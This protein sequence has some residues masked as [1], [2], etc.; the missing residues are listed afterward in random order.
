MNNWISVKA[1]MPEEDGRYL[2]FREFLDPYGKCQSVGILW[3]KKEIK[4]A[5]TWERD[6]NVFYDYSE[7]LD[8]D[9]I[10]DDVRHWM[11][12]PEPPEEGGI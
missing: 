1:R 6:E 12:L 3:F 10:I 4:D 5:F 7:D 8:T 11:S 2:V 9:I